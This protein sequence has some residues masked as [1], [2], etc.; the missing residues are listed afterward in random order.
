MTLPVTPFH[1]P[2][3]S[4]DLTQDR[5]PSAIPHLFPQPHHIRTAASHGNTP[6]F[7]PGSH[8]SSLAPSR[9]T[10]VG[11]P[12]VPPYPWYDPYI[13]PPETLSGCASFHGEPHVMVC[14]PTLVFYFGQDFHANLI[15]QLPMGPPPVTLNGNFQ[16]PG[17]PGNP[18]MGPLGSLPLSPPTTWTSGKAPSLSPW[19]SRSTRRLAELSTRP[20]RTTWPTRSPSWQLQESVGCSIP[21]LHFPAA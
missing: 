13:P 4:F 20:A 2:Y 12:P 14:Q 15:Y 18:P 19:A 3:P 8:V 5:T 9:H 16:P 1:G 10:L 21:L 6:L 7:M 17:P 11:P